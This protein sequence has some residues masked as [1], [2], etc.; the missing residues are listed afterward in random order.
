MRVTGY[1]SGGGRRGNVGTRTLSVMRSAVPYVSGVVNLGPAAGGVDAESIAEAKERAPLTLRTGRRAV[2][3]GDYERLTLEA[4]AEVARTRCQSAQRGNGAVRL[5]VV[6]RV[7]GEATAHHLDDFALAPELVA[8][9]KSRLDEH[10]VIGTA[11]EISTPYYQGISVAALVHAAPGRP[12]ALVRQRAEEAIARFVNPL[13]GG[14]E[15]TGWP[16]STD[17]NAATVTQLLETV[18]GVE[19]VEEALL[20]EYDLRSGRRLG[21]AKDV[22]RL[23]EQSLFLS[24]AHQVVV[25]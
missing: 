21:S 23:D 15:G 7:R 12:A 13:V 11:V 16:F 22:I 10:R 9:I 3:T 8:T 20:F 6:P 2:T 14:S 1:R 24:A 25:R 5:L 18:E 17:L 4:S 19:R